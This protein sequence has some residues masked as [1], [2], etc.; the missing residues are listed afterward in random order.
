MYGKHGRKTLPHFQMGKTSYTY[1]RILQGSNGHWDS[2]AILFL[3][4]K[5]NVNTL[6]DLHSYI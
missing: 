4:S 2:L 1:Q 5:R 3:Y 6:L